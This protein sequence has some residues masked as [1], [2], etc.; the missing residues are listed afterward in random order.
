MA[1]LKTVLTKVRRKGQ[2]KNTAE[3]NKLLGVA[4]KAFYAILAYRKVLIG[5]GLILLFLVLG[6]GGG[7]VSGIGTVINNISHSSCISNPTGS[8]QE[9]LDAYEESGNTLAPEQREEI[10]SGK[11]SSAC[12]GVGYNGEVYPPHQG[13]VSDIWGS[14]RDGGRRLHAG[15]D[16]AAGCGA[17]IYALAGGEVILVSRG[18]EGDN[19]ALGWVKIKHT[20]EFITDYLHMKGSETYV[21]VGDIVGAGDHI[22][23]AGNTG[24]TSAG[25]HLH[26]QTSVDGKLVDPLPVLNDLGFPYAQGA[27][28]SLADYPLPSTAISWK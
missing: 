23:D 5:G 17:P 16:I 22:A 18:S 7:A 6:F 25:C 14:P 8:K 11:V 15:L 3:Q 28:F 12:G 21:K 10:M 24:L 19:G 1:S 4:N 13:T 9:M 26:I 20:D 27:F 2:Q